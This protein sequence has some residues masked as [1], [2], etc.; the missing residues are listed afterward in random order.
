MQ[1]FLPRRTSLI[2]AFVDEAKLYVEFSRDETQTYLRVL[3]DL[4]LEFKLQL[5]GGGHKKALRSFGT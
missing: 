3:L 5:N 4:A 1:R 2:P